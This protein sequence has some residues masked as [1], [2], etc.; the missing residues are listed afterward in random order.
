MIMIEYIL[1]HNIIMPLVFIVYSPEG[2]YITQQTEYLS[3]IISRRDTEIIKFI[4]LATTFIFYEFESFR[5]NNPLLE[6]NN[7]NAIYFFINIINM[8]NIKYLIERTKILLQKF[9]L[10]LENKD[11]N[12]F[13]YYNNIIKS[14]NR[15]NPFTINSSFKH[16]LFF[17]TN[18]KNYSDINGKVDFNILT[19]FLRDVVS[20]NGGDWLQYIESKFS[21]DIENPLLIC[22]FNNELNKTTK[23]ESSFFIYN[24][25]KGIKIEDTNNSA[26]TL[27]N[28]TYYIGTKC[29]KANI[30]I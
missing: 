2:Y 9:L 29:D 23:K 19:S 26:Y 5:N 21:K 28:M 24:F 14:Y 7:I 11:T 12:S 20:N 15:A 22:N 4:D 13:N 8:V 10:S 16:D 25:T 6:N 27:T 30:I 1:T 3:E 17:I 18:E